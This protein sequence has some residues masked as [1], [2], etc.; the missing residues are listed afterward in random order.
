MGM[1]IVEDEPGD[2]PAWIENAIEMPM[3]MTVMPQQLDNLNWIEDLSGGHFQ[4]TLA[5]SEF[6][7]VN[8]MYQPK[9]QLLE[10][11]WYRLR[12]V[13]GTMNFFVVFGLPDTCEWYLL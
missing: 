4:R 10:H 3:M 12:F 7:I 13:M 6:M 11:Q 2:L 1:I 8:G 9:L 5:S